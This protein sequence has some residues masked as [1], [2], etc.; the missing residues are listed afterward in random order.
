MS[1]PNVISFEGYGFRYKRARE[2]ALAG[3]DLAVGR[4]ELLGIVGPSGAGKSTLAASV[5][6][7]IPHLIKGDVSGRL[8]ID[9]VDTLSLSPRD[10]A[11][12][13]GTVFQDFESQIFSSRVD[14]ETAFGPENLGLDRDE[15]VSRVRRSL[16]LV[17]L[18]EKKNRVPAEL[19]G[20]EKQR[21][22]IASILA[23]EPRVLVFD[24]PITDLDPEGQSEV[25]AL[26]ERILGENR[27]T[28][29]LVDHESEHLVGAD[30]VAVLAAGRLARVGTP[31]EI[32]GDDDLLAKYRLK[33][34]A[35]VQILKALG[36]K[37][38]PLSIEEAVSVLNGLRVPFDRERVNGL[39]RGDA[40]RDASYGPP[41]IEID[42]LSFSYGNN[43]VISGLDLT[44]REREF[45]ALVGPNGS[46]KT[47]LVKQINGLLSPDEGRV[48]VSGRPPRSYGVREISEMVG[49]VH[50]NPDRMIFSER[51][52]D[53]AAFGLVVRNA[54]RATIEKRVSDVLAVVG[55]G[56][57]ADDDPYL[58]TKGE[59][60]RLAVAATLAVGP[61]ILI[62]DEPTTGLDNGEIDDMMNLLSTLNG[63]GHTVICIT[64]NMDVVAR[65]CHRLVVLAGGSIVADGTTRAVFRRQETL[66]RGMIVAPPAVRMGIANGFVTLSAR[67]FIACTGGAG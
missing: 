23:M 21:L 49:F 62:L 47:T 17:S 43:R 28:A 63:R 65:Y 34:L 24:E 39:V 18:A 6:A 5:G 12:V 59:R 52:F 51:V 42:H 9:G 67:E 8:L 3:I 38:P 31:A 58:L 35:H 56:D 60:Q 53:E 64:H 11:G 13:V 10:L 54:D 32:F 61:R 48:L 7:F 45:V 30:R 36:V 2:S 40:E 4:G 20:G 15:I 19:S 22:V 16:A 33:P 14:V 55:L 57:R 50:Q 26:L 1:H 66:D 41:L 37:E 29:L 27:R 25:L 46:G 44:V